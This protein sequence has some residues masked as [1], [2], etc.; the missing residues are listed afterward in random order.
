MRVKNEVVKLTKSLAVWLS[1]YGIL[2]EYRWAIT[3]TI[4]ALISLF[5]LVNQ[6]WWFSMS[7]QFGDLI[8]VTAAVQCVT[9][10]PNW[11]LAFETCDPFGRPFNNSTVLINLLSDLGLRY[12]HTNLIG[13]AFTFGLICLCAYLSYK[14]SEKLA[15]KS[16]HIVWLL[17]W[18]SPSMFL[19]S[20]R[21][22]IDSLVAVLVVL[23]VFQRKPSFLAFILVLFA[24]LL[25]FY[26]LILVL[27]I[28]FSR[29]ISLSI[30]II[31]SLCFSWIFLLVFEDIPLVYQ[32]T[33]QIGAI[34]F[35]I[36]QP[37]LF[38][39]EFFDTD[40]LP[41][42]FQYTS[43]VPFVALVF[44]YF[45]FYRFT[46]SG[47]STLKESLPFEPDSARFRSGLLFLGI[48]VVGNSY[49]YRLVFLN[50]FLAALIFEN[51]AARPDYL[52]YLTLA[53]TSLLSFMQ[54]PLNF[55]FDFFLYFF[56]A[57]WVAMQSSLIKDF[58][59]LKKKNLRNVEGSKE[60]SL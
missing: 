51:K 15:S 40:W 26:P 60:L 57:R 4:F 41:P 29:K 19:L 13:Y 37:F 55:I 9:D 3:P 33:V 32:N 11:T 16:I 44:L 27:A 59:L 58:I 43:V 28:M 50:I 36:R 7:K 10:N 14:L 46:T 1:R 52:V 56:L 21:G 24:S 22:N 45:L 12:V 23:F 42:K 30:K 6:F 20:E 47:K 31:L 8:G 34:S 35:G 49:D 17:L 48:F 39:Q 25:K 53:I 18:N 54:F 38:A 2:R 5:G